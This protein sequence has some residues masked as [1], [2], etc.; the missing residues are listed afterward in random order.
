MTLT[1]DLKEL[2]F[3][4]VTKNVLATLIL[5]SIMHYYIMVKMEESKKFSRVENNNLV[6]SN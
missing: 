1:K 2:F 3:V 6:Q 4:S 5:H